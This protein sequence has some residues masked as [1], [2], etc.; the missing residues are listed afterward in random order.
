MF[1]RKKRRPSFAAHRVERA[2]QL[3]RLRGDAAV[4]LEAR[5]PASR[6]RRRSAGGAAHRR[7]Q[8]AEHEH[9]RGDEQ[10][11]RERARLRRREP[12]Q[13]A[14]VIVAP[15]AGGPAAAPASRCVAA[16]SADRAAPARRIRAALWR[17][18]G[19]ALGA[20]VAV[21][22]PAARC[23]VRRQRGARRRPRGARRRCGAVPVAGGVALVAGGAALAA[24]GADAAA[25]GGGAARRPARPARL[26]QRLQLRAEVED[27]ARARLDLGRRRARRDLREQP[28]LLEHRDQP[29]G[30]APIRRASRS[31]ARARLPFGS[32]RIS[33]CVSQVSS[34]STRVTASSTRTIGGHAYLRS[35]AKL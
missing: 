25:G 24:A 9:D 7:E 29:A 4:G 17:V 28:R 2:A 16:A 19:A 3:R 13:S 21:R 26:R 1:F 35:S 8:E 32:V 33:S 18:G 11:E 34:G 14:G 20:G 12:G 15:S 22:A 23:G 5:R 31:R 27:L 6:S 30:V 10:A